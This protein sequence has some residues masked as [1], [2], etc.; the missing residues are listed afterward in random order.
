[1]RGRVNATEVC[2]AT[3]RPGGYPLMRIDGMLPTAGDKG[4]SAR[5]A[6]GQGVQ[7]AWPTDCSRTAGTRV[8]LIRAS[9]GLPM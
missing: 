7:S 5:R 1:M 2:I 3:P 9:R 4:R 6:P 8:R